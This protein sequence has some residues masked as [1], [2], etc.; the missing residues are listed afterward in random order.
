MFFSIEVNQA[1]CGKPPAKKPFPSNML[2]MV[3]GKKKGNPEML[4]DWAYFQGQGRNAS[5]DVHCLSLRKWASIGK[6]SF[7]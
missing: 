1:N 4:G 2:A 5:N 7:I 6:G 3:M